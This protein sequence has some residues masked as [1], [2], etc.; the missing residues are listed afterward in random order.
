MLEV[1]SL[2]F[3][4]CSKFA[5]FKIQRDKKKMKPLKNKLKKLTKKIAKELNN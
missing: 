3:V 4:A 2:Y 5:L 1:A